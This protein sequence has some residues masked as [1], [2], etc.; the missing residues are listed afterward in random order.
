MFLLLLAQA[1]SES[2]G[3][4]STEWTTII[5][6]AGTALATVV[7]SFLFSR[8]KQ[9]T[10]DF[11]AFMK[12]SADFREEI[13]KELER[14]QEEYE[15]EIEKHR[16]LVAEKENMLVHL[17]KENEDYITHYKFLA[18]FMPQIVWT[19]NPMGD[20]DYCNQRWFDY[21]GMSVDQAKGSGWLAVIHPDDVSKIKDEWQA[22]IKKGLPFETVTRFKRVA[23]GAYRWFMIRVLPRFDSLGRIV[24]WIGTSTDIHDFYVRIAKT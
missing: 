6:S 21:T 4:S 11:A 12:E 1:A 7:T 19:A 23:D 5:F 16:S 14:K 9:R 3:K 22:A 15:L 17:R 24:Q 2:A 13:R 8:K 10:D 18:D 20:L